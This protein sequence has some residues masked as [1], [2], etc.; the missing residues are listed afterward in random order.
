MTAR[1]PV[2]RYLA[3]TT[4]IVGLVGM[5]W[6]VTPTRASAQQPIDSVL[7]ATL[8][9]FKGDTIYHVRVD[10]RDST[11]RIHLGEVPLLKCKFTVLDEGDVSSYRSAWSEKRATGWQ[12][13]TKRKVWS[14]RPA[15]SDTV[16][17]VVAKVS[18][19]DPELISRVMPR[20]FVVDLTDDFIIRVMTV[21]GAGEER[22]F[23]E[24]MGQFQQNW[25]PFMRQP[26]LDVVVTEKDAQT[27]YYAL[28]PGTPI[29]LL[30]K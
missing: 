7:M 24:K 1:N 4:H 13:V 27:L 28:E 22:S 11:F 12:S 20:R 25:I 18:K 2:A 3:R 30:D 16:V 26:H 6:L 23:E 17:G 5:V 8:Q 29:I 15:V 14:G 10:T 21:E 9:R 19:V